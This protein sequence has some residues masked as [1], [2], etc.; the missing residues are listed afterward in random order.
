MKDKI[1]ERLVNLILYQASEDW[2]E[3]WLDGMIV[4]TY[5]KQ[6]RIKGSQEVAPFF[7]ELAHYALK[8]I[9]TD[10]GHNPPE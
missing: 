4:D 3:H 7:N 5:E 6:G 2:T 8:N 9:A 10:D 1:V